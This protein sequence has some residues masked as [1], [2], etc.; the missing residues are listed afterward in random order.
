MKLP[1][2]ITLLSTLLI[3]LSSAVLVVG[4]SAYIRARMTADDLAA[5]VMNQTASRIDLQLDT[6]LSQAPKLNR[7]CAQHIL[8][9]RVQAADFAGDIAFFRDGMELA[10]GLTGYFI[11][12]EASGEA[13]GITRVTGEP[14][15]WQSARDPKSGRYEV[16]EYRLA[17]YPGHALRLDPDTARPDI[18]TRPW[19]V[20][21]KAAGKSIWTETFLFLGAEGA[22][23]VAGVSFATPAYGKDGS[24][25]A[26]LDADYDL[27]Q[28]CRF[29][30]TLNL[31]QN[32]IGFVIETRSGG[33]EQVIA[34]PDPG[35]LT[36][37]GNPGDD[38]S[39]ELI[40][41]GEFPD[42][43]VAAFSRAMV[44][45]DTRSDTAAWKSLRFQADGDS[46]LGMYRQLGT[47]STPPWIA[48]V[49]LSETEVLGGVHRGI[50]ET[51]LISM[52]VLAL[53]IVSSLLVAGQVARPLE[54]LAQIARA[55]GLLQFTR[56]PVA[57]SVIREVDDLAIAME[58]MKAGLRSFQKFVPAGL[59]FSAV[60]S[61]QESSLTGER[62][63]LTIVFTDVANFTSIAEETSPE[64]LVEQ[65]R[66]YFG[67]ISREISALG[68]TVDKYI[69][70][71]VMAFWGAPAL[72]P[73]QALNACS[74]ALR[75]QLALKQLA[76][77]WTASG[78]KL[79]NTRVGIHTG[80]AIVGNI[81]SD[82][83]LNYTVIGDAVNLASRLE[84]MNKHYGTNTLIS[85]DTYNQ[86]RSGVF[87]RPIDY[88]SVKGKH[89]PTLVYELLG[90]RGDDMEGL[91]GLIDDFGQAIQCYRNR[92]WEGAIRI[93]ESVLAR[94]PDDRPSKIM[95]ARCR[96]Y[97]NKP[98]GADWDGVFRPDSK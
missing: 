9:G 93:F 33:R 43:R 39:R 59:V 19:Y 79:F 78:K 88:V 26:V 44:A 41:P 95:L 16:H 46:Y 15:V 98:P 61:G 62:R 7:L 37:G 29:L 81:G 40:A 42:P 20:Q 69:G 22:R 5:Q 17:D 4:A 47:D 28:L 72:D 80:E 87:A 96:A 14:R 48:C 86:A 71:S 60:T 57:H 3:L 65:L 6:L 27:Q 38:N 58:D 49:V 31:G 13:T 36:R 53:G 90:L 25:V 68:G 12:L 52:C 74:A 1:L 73:Q 83:R 75:C 85:E 45:T 18:R 30:R 21:A 51:I 97:Q 2:R 32:G 67:V 63:M 64:D 91:D 54:Y 24:L 55:V 92:D 50:R 10:K 84:G 11:G 82:A 23:N 89:K 35:L 76:E 70:D 34:Y 66:D 56:Q 77:Q 94:R 8:E